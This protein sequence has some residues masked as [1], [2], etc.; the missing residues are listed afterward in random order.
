LKRFALTWE[1]LIQMPSRFTAE[2][3]NRAERIESALIRFAVDDLKAQVIK[4]NDLDA[5][6]LE[7]EF[8]Q[9]M[10]PERSPRRTDGVKGP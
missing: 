9:A 3:P 5:A 6:A 2:A 10:Q 4:N 1:E 7:A 8:T